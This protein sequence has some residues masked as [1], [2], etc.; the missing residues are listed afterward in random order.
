MDLKLL[1]RCK[2]LLNDKKSLKLSI[3]I[4]EDEIFKSLSHK[5]RRD[6]IRTIGNEGKLSFT[7]IKNHIAKIDSP[8]L[9]YHIKS[10]QPL[11]T[12]K[13]NKYE[14]TEIGRA[15]YILLIKTDQSDKITKYRK[16]FIYAYI[17]TVFCWVI[18]QTLIPFFLSTN[19][20]E[21]F[22]NYIPIMIIINSLA[23]INYAAIW[24]L[25]NV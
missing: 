21:N 16:R 10:L 3:T 15:A 8:T 13:E 22:F 18:M 1:Y 6:I 14:L 12:S 7:A 24:K 23:V 17:I 4:D 5:I 19:T 25:K 2:K 20:T 9:S 11:L